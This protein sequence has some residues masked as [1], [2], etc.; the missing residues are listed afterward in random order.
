MP[1]HHE[2]QLINAQAWANQLAQAVAALLH[3]AIQA[4]GH[5]VLAVSGGKSPIPFFHALREQDIEWSCVRVTLVDERCIPNDHADNNGR[6][7]CAELLRS[8]ASDAQWVALVDESEASMPALDTLVE[9]AKGRWAAL[10]RID[11]MVLGMGDDGHTA[12]LFPD[13]DT[14]Q[15]GLDLNNTERLLAVVPPAAP[16]PRI[17]ATLAE[18]LAAKH[19]LLAIGGATKKSVYQQALAARDDRLPISH[20]LHATHPSVQV[21]MH[22]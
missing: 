3:E 13:A 5:A 18:I 9:R 10:P 7:V 22:P 21:W 20:V 11:V 4:H 12:S 1:H 14:L 2:H 19:V 6:M 15:Q 16:H 8:R 17:S